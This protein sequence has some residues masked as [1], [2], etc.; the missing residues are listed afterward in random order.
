MATIADEP[1]SYTDSTRPAVDNRP[2]P[3]GWIRQFDAER[4]HEFFVDTNA[5]PPRSSWIHPLDDDTYLSTLT[6]A[7]REALQDQKASSSSASASAS[8]TSKLTGLHKSPTT[9]STSS[10]AAA[11]LPP[12]AAAGSS[13]SS[14][15]DS[16]HGIKKL[17]RSLKDKLTASTHEE[18]VAA[19]A[20]RAADD[21]AALQMQAAAR[22]A[23]NEAL[24]TGQPQLLARDRDGRD[25]WIEPPMAPRGYGGGYG[26]DYGGQQQR[27]RY[28]QHPY[29]DPNAR[30]VRMQAPGGYG[31]GGYGGG[32]YGPGYGYGGSGLGLPI[33]GGLLG[34]AL[35]GSLLF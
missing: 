12:R 35:L 33:V 11:D 30:F 24:R 32:G 6:S 26:G 7:E 17:G 5:K 16:P 10:T 20:Q 21:E 25:V 15:Q 34:G 19:R 28:T 2:L 4:D 9:S 1:P 29:T 31:Y 3:S 27:N 23:M 14:S 8:S 22:H 18:R 13:G